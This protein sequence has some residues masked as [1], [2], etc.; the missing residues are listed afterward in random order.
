MNGGAGD[1]LYV[2][3]SLL[4]RV[5]EV[6]NEVDMGGTDTVQT[7]L[8]YTLG[9]YIENLVLTG[10]A[11]LEGNGNSLNNAI[12]GNSGNNILRGQAGDDVLNGAAGVD[13]LYGGAGNDTY[14]LDN[15]SDQAIEIVNGVDAGGID[16]VRAA[17]SYA[18]GSVFENVILT[19]SANLDATGNALD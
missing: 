19:G 18:L 11:N 10:T 2:V 1:D 16:T 13:I 15:V 3:D 6:T 9:S 4:D 5:S 8:S 17:F 7:S 12:T 14:V